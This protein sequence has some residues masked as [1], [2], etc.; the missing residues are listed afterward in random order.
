MEALYLIVGLIEIRNFWSPHHTFNK[1]R[2]EEN[3]VQ[4]NEPL[5]KIPQLAIHLNRSVNENGL[6]LNPQQH[7]R[8]IWND[9]SSDTTNL[10]DFIS[11]AA[12]LDRQ[13]I[14]LGI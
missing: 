5:A 3:L 8:P 2:I 7:L 14:R 11:S 12:G 9:T 6:I 10:I 4:I 13:R 1:W